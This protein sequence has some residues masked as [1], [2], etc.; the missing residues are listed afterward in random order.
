MGHEIDVDHMLFFKHPN[1]K[2][3]L[4]DFGRARSRVRFFSRQEVLNWFDC[5]NTIVFLDYREAKIIEFVNTLPENYIIVDFVF[6]FKKSDNPNKI[7]IETEVRFR[8]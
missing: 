6:D 3:D 2:R 4:D 7:F 5:N 8:F 1:I